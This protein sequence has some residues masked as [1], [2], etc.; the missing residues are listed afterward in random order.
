M[1][2]TTALLLPMLGMIFLTFGIMMW[3]LKLRYRAVLQDGLNP[4]YFRLYRGAKLPDYLVKVTQHFDN[5][6][7]TPI[8]FYTAIILLVALKIS[9][10]FYV[11]LSWLF[12]LSRLI[13][14]IIHTTNNRVKHR[15]NIFIFSILVLIILWVKISIDIFSL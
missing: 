1:S 8:L 3:M 14:S 11:T 2:Q 12:F 5:L 7:E 15:K 10:P 6:L 13:H 9:N 4:K